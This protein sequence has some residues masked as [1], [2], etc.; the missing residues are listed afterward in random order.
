MY[1]AF[2]NVGGAGRVTLAEGSVETVIDFNL[3]LSVGW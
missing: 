1:C 3:A 2:D